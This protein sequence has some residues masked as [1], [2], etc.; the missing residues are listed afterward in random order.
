MQESVDTFRRDLARILRDAENLPQ[1]VKKDMTFDHSMFCSTAKDVL[2]H[3]GV[4][5]DEKGR[6][7][8]EEF[9]E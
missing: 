6:I 8:F 9:K 3:L 2:A 4:L 7:H 1:N 5:I